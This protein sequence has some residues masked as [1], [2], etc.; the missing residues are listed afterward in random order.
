MFKKR[1]PIAA[2]YAA[3]RVFK[4]DDEAPEKSQKPEYPAP[5]GD[6]EPEIHTVYAC[7]TLNDP[8]P[9]YPDSLAEEEPPIAPVYAGPDRMKKHPRMGR[10]YAGP[11]PDKRN[12]ELISAVYAGP[13][14]M[15]Q[16]MA[17]VYAGPEW[18]ANKRGEADV[19]DVY[20]GPAPEEPEDT[21]GKPMTMPE[22]PPGLCG[23]VMASPD[24]RPAFMT[25]PADTPPGVCPG[26]GARVPDGFKFCAECGT[27][28]PVVE[29][30]PECGVIVEKDQKFCH[31]CGRKLQ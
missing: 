22:I 28:I 4:K 15:R 2:L 8:E 30:C 26:C 14:M 1:T 10:V 16:P 21:D 18:F 6:E 31:E 9:G 7:P 12:E 5:Q 27:P 13:E 3:P 20:A 24:T 25:K 23:L 19:Q 29:H 17:L 11:A